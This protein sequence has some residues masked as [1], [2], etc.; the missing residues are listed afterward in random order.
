[1]GEYCVT[2]RTNPYATCVAS[3]W[4][5]SHRGPLGDLYDGSG[6]VLS[7]FFLS[8]WSGYGKNVFVSQGGSESVLEPLRKELAMSLFQ[9]CAKWDAGWFLAEDHSE[10]E[11]IRLALDSLSD[12]SHVQVDEDFNVLY[13]L[14]PPVTGARALEI[15]DYV[16]RFR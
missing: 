1:M 9:T 6:L 4:R 11:R 7:T 8:W 5:G 12:V 16:E 3:L 14:D 13:K 10:A 15:N 2:A